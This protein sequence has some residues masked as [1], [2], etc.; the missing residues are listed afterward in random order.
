MKVQLSNV[1]FAMNNNYSQTKKQ[2]INNSSINRTYSNQV[3][4][5][6]IKTRRVLEFFG[7]VKKAPKVDPFDNLLK[8]SQM[9]MPK[10]PELINLENELN[11]TR[12]LFRTKSDDWRINHN[13]NSREEAQKLGEELNKLYDKIENTK[14][15]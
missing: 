5:T 6:G 8:L 4:F 2:S 10:N 9:E 13:E 3:N 15:D 7:L 1:S 11:E 12:V 14:W